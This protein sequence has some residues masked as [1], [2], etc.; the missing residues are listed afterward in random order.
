MKNRRIIIIDRDERS[1]MNDYAIEKTN[2]EVKNHG[3][4]RKENRR[5]CGEG[6]K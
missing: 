2:G 6:E 1:L 5:R 3:K 4:K